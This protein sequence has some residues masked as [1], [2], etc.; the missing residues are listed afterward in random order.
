MIYPGKLVRQGHRDVAI[1]E[2]VQAR[3]TA[4]GYGGGFKVGLFDATMRA[5]VELFQAQNV[6]RNNLPLAIDGAIGPTTWA[7]LF[8][9]EADGARDQD[10]SD[11]LLAAALAVARSQVGVRETAGQPNRGKE[12]D[13]YIRCCGLD[14][15]KADPT[16]GYAWCA[17]FVYWCFEEAA[18]KLGQPNPV[19]QAAGVLNVWRRSKSQRIGDLSTEFGVKRLRPGSL[20]VMNFGKGRGHIGFVERHVGRRLFTIEGNSNND[21]SR[22]GTGVF[23]LARRTVGDAKLIGYLDFGA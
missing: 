16:Q 22:D 1:V 3:L 10:A 11:P 17:A 6:D 7:T 19:P 2:A 13:E 23:R 18:Q 8:G 14:P 20:F 12:V 4:L 9:I 5:T 15:D 21:G